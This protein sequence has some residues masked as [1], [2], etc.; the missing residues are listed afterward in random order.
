MKEGFVIFVCIEIQTWKDEGNCYVFDFFWRRIELWLRFDFNKKRWDWESFKVG[1]KAEKV[2]GVF[3]LSQVCI[4]LSHVIPYIIGSGYFAGFGIG[5]D[6]RD[7]AWAWRW[8][9]ETWTGLTFVFIVEDWN[10]GLNLLKTEF[11]ILLYFFIKILDTNF[12]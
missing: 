5:L 10:G 7:Y 4:R 12:W 6:S 9:S 1:D 11:V 8:K 3:F 2:V